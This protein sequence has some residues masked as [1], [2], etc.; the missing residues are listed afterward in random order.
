MLSLAHRRV[1]AALVVLVVFL[2]WV[3]WQTSYP[4]LTPSKAA[5]TNDDHKTNAKTAEE[6]HQAT[7]DAIATYTLWLMAFTGI[8]AIATAGLGA[9][10]LFQ[11]RLARS[12]FLSSHRPKIR[13]KH[14]WLNEDIWQQQPVIVTLVCVNT[15]V[16]DAKLQEIGLRYEIVRN[17]AT[18]PPAPDIDHVLQA[19]GAAV[20]SGKN[21]R[22]PLINIGRVITAAENT[23]IQNKTASLF[24]VGYISYLD[25]ADLM[26]ITGFC[27]V[28]EFPHNT[29]ARA[30]NSRFRIFKDP[31]YEYED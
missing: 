7:E 29:I 5:A 24:C 16:A 4:P 14:I 20:R 3:D 26:R 13:L 18:L 17:G 31:D 21:H 23:E 1:I 15:G 6:R 2:C 11:V 12:E 25:A 30:D 28:L 27:R 8:L 19:N 9:L 10:N 22:F